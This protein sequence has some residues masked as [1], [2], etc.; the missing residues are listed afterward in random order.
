LLYFKWKLKLKE[1][2]TKG[3]NG[4]SFFVAAADIN[5]RYIASKPY[6]NKKLNKTRY[7]LAERDVIQGGGVCPE[8]NKTF[9]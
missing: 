8:Y 1:Y 6:W 4:I 3:I 5:E 2:F 9:T 7:Y